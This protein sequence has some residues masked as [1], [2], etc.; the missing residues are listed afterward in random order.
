MLFF[1][2]QKMALTFNCYNECFCYAMFNIA[3]LISINDSKSFHQHFL[4]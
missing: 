2:K 3:I 1:K 4:N